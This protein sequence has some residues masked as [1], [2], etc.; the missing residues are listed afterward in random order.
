MPPFEHL[1]AQSRTEKFCSYETRA[2]ILL[3]CPIFCFSFFIFLL[4]DSK[5]LP[6]HVRHHTCRVRLCE[7][8]VAFDHLEGLVAQDFSDLKQGSAV[9]G[10]IAGCRMS[11]V[12]EAEI[13]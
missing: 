9:H 8:R 4:L 1:C 12:V 7:V 3:S 10:Q 6:V 11:Q 5:Y 13:L 2:P